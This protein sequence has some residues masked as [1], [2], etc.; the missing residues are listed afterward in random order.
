V[1][2]LRALTTAQYQNTISDLTSWAMSDAAAGPALV[3]EI[4]SALGAIPPNAPV[5]P[6]SLA[7]ANLFPEGG[8]LRADQDIQF[9]RVQGFYTV[10]LAVANAL[11]SSSRFGK[12]VGSC[13]T[14]SNTSNDGACLTSFIQSFGARAL[15]RPISQADVTNYTGIYGASTTADPAAY[16]DVITV[17]LNSPEFLYFVEHGDTAVDSMPGVYQLGAYELAS[18]LSYHAWDSMPDAELWQAAVDGS[19]LQDAVYQK[20]AVRLFTDPRGQAAMHRFFSDYLQTNDSGG[21]R[22]TGGLNYHNLTLRNSDPLFKAFAGSDLPSAN[23]YQDMVDDALS[24]VDYYA[25]TVPGTLHDLLTSNLSF[26][27]SDDVAKLYGLPTWDGV[28]TPPSFPAGQRPG[29]FTRAL[30]VSAGVDTSPILKG[31]YLRRFVLCDTIGPPPPQ[32][33]KA[34]VA[35]STTQSTR[36]QVEALTSV[37]P[38]SGCHTNWL[39]PLGFTTED[40]DGLGRFRTQQTLYNSDGSV[41]TTVPIDTATAPYVEMGDDKTQ[42]ASVSDLMTDIEASDK[43]AACLTRN[44]F[45]YAFGR[46]EDLTLDACALEAI[47]TKLEN[48]GHIADW[49]EAVVYTSAFKQRTFQ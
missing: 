36:Q 3:A 41:A 33:A 2:Q 28:S 30:V 16:A 22:G 45:R 35:L 9:S 12:V 21:P 42:V 29:L 25:W 17:M 32:A 47:R 37:S 14:D 38:C 5:V 19:I 48:G 18:R 10:S 24:M 39:N 6:A 43:P 23:L 46:F 20:E 26:A 15:R 49:L 31:V 11:T 13:A 34:V 4:A 27:K 44:Y 1:D 8:W 40:F 7:F